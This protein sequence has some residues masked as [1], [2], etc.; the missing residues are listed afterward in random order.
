MSLI[1]TINNI[2][3][4]PYY[5]WWKE[6]DCTEII[7]DFSKDIVAGLSD[8]PITGM[9]KC[10]GALSP[11]SSKVNKW[12]VE[13]SEDTVYIARTLKHNN[14]I[15]IDGKLTV[16]DLCTLI[17]GIPTL[18]LHF[19]GDIIL[20]ERGY[21]NGNKFNDFLYDVKNLTI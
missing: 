18:T 21:A 1:N 12:M 10:V 16:Y 17:A 3:S 9:Y 19:I 15:S 14:L 13:N 2:V 6:N 8:G 11:K 5:Y 20:D 7:T 4:N